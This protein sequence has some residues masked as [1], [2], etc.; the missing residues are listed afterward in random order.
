MLDNITDRLDNVI[1][2]L[3]AYYIAIS[4]FLRAFVVVARHLDLHNQGRDEFHISHFVIPAI[5]GRV[6]ALTGRV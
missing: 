3:V 4:L 5:R 6:R 1:V 2:R